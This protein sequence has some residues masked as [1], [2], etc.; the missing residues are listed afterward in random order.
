MKGP[1]M[2]R[3][4]LEGVDLTRAVGLTTAQLEIACGDSR[5]RLPEGVN[6]PKT[7]PCGKDD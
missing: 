1:R 7:W 4:R 5:T 3:T 6:A 2:F